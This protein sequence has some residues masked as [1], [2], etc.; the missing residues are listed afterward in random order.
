MNTS[1]DHSVPSAESYRELIAQ[2]ARELWQI[3]G[4][5]EGQDA[6]IW[7]EAE[8]DLVRR[9]LI[10]SSATGGDTQHASE[11]IDT[12][13]LVDRLN[14]FGEQTAARRATSLDLTNS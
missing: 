4:R 6:A 9:R 13:K 1:I 7:L 5:P 12:A 10:P 14:D 11:H 2:R 8:Q 3:R